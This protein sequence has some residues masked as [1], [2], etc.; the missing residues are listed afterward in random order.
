MRGS[1]ASLL[2]M[3]WAAI[4][5]AQ[6]A[7]EWLAKSEQLPPLRGPRRL[8]LDGEAMTSSVDDSRRLPLRPRG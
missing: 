6:R 5:D 7:N 2:A 1:N 8:A 3:T 4:G